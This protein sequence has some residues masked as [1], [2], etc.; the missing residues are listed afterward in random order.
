MSTMKVF[1]RLIFQIGLEFANIVILGQRK[2]GI[3]GKIPPNFKLEFN[4]I[5]GLSRLYM[6]RTL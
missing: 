6:S 3:S 4:T 5:H 1:L 2:T